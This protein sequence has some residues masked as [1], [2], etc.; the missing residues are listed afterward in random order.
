MIPLVAGVG[1]TVASALLPAIA[2]GRV[3]ALAALRDSTGAEP[4]GHRRMRTVV[5]LA[6]AAVIAGGGLALLNSGRGQGFDGLATMV[7]GA[8]IMFCALVLVM[9]VVIIVLSAPLRWVLGR[10]SA[11]PDGWRWATRPGTRCGSGRPRPR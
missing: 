11:R 1:I 6:A 3:P 9:P 5:T 8:M 2:A 10:C 7:A 4:T